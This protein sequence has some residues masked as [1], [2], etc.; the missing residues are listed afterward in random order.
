MKQDKHY[1]PPDQFVQHLDVLLH[2]WNVHGL[3]RIDDREGREGSAIVDEASARLEDTSD[4][5]DLEENVCIL[6]EF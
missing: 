2:L 3:F 4:E 1:A 6:E 5:N